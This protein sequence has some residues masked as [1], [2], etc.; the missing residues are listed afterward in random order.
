MEGFDPTNHTPEEAI[1]FIDDALSTIQSNRTGHIALIDAIG[2]LTK[3][4]EEN[5]QLKQN[6]NVKD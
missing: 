5:K 4:V 6:Q 1:K 2:T 3:L